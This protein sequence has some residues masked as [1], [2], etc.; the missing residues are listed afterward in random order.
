ML[1]GVLALPFGDRASALVP[2][3]ETD[4]ESPLRE[5]RAA[6]HGYAADHPVW[7]GA[8][9]E[10]QLRAQLLRTT[11]TDGRVGTGDEFVHGPYL[12]D[13]VPLNPINGGRSVVVVQHMP[14]SATDEGGW[15]YSYETG[16]VRANLGGS[17]VDGARYF[18]L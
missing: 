2:G 12:A 9:G 8:L 10:W 3:V 7:P 16:E 5:L 11:D 1:V 13:D 15:I 14:D 6:I 4:V 18:D 17:G